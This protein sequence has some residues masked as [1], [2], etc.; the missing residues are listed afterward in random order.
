[1]LALVR[2]QGPQGIQWDAICVAVKVPTVA[3]ALNLCHLEVSKHVWPT[4][5]YFHDMADAGTRWDHSES[6]DDELWELL[7]CHRSDTGNNSEFLFSI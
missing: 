4:F 6:P 5:L 2:V 3:Y 1:M 7:T